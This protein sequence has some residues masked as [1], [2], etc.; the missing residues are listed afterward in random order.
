MIKTAI[1]LNFLLLFCIIFTHGFIFF[2]QGVFWDGWIIYPN[3]LNYHD[4]D[5]VWMIYKDTGRPI[6]FYIQLFTTFFENTLLGYRLIF[7]WSIQLTTYST[8]RL[9]Q[10]LRLPSNTAWL[11]AIF[12]TSFPAFLVGFE[13]IQLPNVVTYSF[14]MSATWLFISAIY[15]KQEIH[16]KALKSIQLILS[17]ILYTASFDTNSLLVYFYP[18]WALSF[19]TS[20]CNKNQNFFSKNTAIHLLFF[21]FPVLWWALNRYYFPTV[22]LY[23]NYNQF[24]ISKL[25]INSLIFILFSGI[26]PMVESVTLFIR[27]PLLFLPVLAIILLIAFSFKRNFI[28]SPI[29]DVQYPTK[30]TLILLCFGVILFVMG[31]FPY[32]AVGKFPIFR[33]WETRHAI[34]TLLP[35]SIMIVSGIQLLQN[36]FGAKQTKLINIFIIFLL[37]SFSAR[38]IE[39][40]LMWQA[41]W[42]KDSTFM[43]HLLHNANASLFSTYYVQDEW[44]IEDHSLLYKYDSEYEFYEYAGMFRLIWG[45]QSRLGLDLK[46]ADW[47]EQQHLVEQDARYRTGEYNLAGFDPARQCKATLILSKTDTRSDMKI[48]L[49]YIVNQIVDPDLNKQPLTKLSTLE[50][51]PHP[52]NRCL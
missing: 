45:D 9:W 19:I 42:I 11:L 26:V 13:V 43:T 5:I 35:V 3:L 4:W 18:F 17:L 48:A 27:L 29:I 23:A 20:I 32:L 38:H 33:S 6:Y 25:G 30:Q 36:K 51:I 14:F 44:P 37:T 39:N 7:I 10:I 15:H 28:G 16:L 12:S 52:D 40:Y 46:A 49:D 34:L 2:N 1:K 31:A 21:L 50:V 8:Y 41:R 47:Q 22:G 24:D